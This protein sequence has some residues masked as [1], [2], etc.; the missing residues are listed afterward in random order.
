MTISP[1]RSAFVKTTACSKLEG[2]LPTALTIAGNAASGAGGLPVDLKTFHELG[3]YGIGALTCIVSFQ[4][5]SNWGHQFWP[6]PPEQILAQV[7]SAITIRDISVAK[8]GMLGTVPSIEAAAQALA[9]QSWE[10]VV[11]DPVLICKG[12]A[13]A[14]ALDVDRALI[15]H[16]LPEA[17]VITPNLFEMETLS[18]RTVR[19]RDDLCD[20]AR[21]IGDLGVPYVVAKGGLGMPG[22]D[23]ID[24]LWDGTDI[25]EF[26]A[27]K[28]G[29]QPLNGA[30]CTLAAAITAQ[31]AKGHEVIDAVGFARDFVTHAIDHKTEL[32]MPHDAVWQG[33]WR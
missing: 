18:G 8:I 26:R 12:Q 20:A 25:T 23:A 2:A 32:H 19:N 33:G 21:A 15:K 11:L 30:G 16:L 28:R 9:L 1:D 3:V 31:L 10:H 4:E 27:R 13:T 17:T 14:A 6:V 22:E 24:I 5:G 7:R 29:N